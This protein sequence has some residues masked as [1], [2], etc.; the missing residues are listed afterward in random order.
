VIR[1]RKCSASALTMPI[2]LTKP[3]TAVTTQMVRLGCVD[4]LPIPCTGA[5]RK[6]KHP[7]EEEYKRSSN[8]YKL[9]LQGWPKYGGI[10]LDVVMTSSLPPPKRGS[11][12]LPGTFVSCGQ[13]WGCRTIRLGVRARIRPRF[14]QEPLARRVDNLHQVMPV[15]K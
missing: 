11:P 15:V 7:V 8:L 1:N 6:D 9:D 4:P 14:G 12:S 13:Q 10:L 3:L 2:F 5:R